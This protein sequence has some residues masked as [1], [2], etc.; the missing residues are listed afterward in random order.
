MGNPKKEKLNLD[1]FRRYGIELELNSFDLRNRSIGYENGRL[2]EGTYYIGNLVQKTIKE[3]VLIHKWGNDHNNDKWIIKPDASCGIEVCTPVCK[4]WHDLKK[5]CKVVDNFASDSKILADD[6]CSLHVHIEVADLS[7]DQV[8][9]IFTWWIKCEPVF[10]D[11]V[12][13]SRKRNRYCQFIG[14]SDFMDNI[15]YGFVS[16]QD[17]LQN[18]GEYKYYSAN[19]YHIYRQKRDSIEFRIMDHSACKDSLAVKNWTRLLLHF[20]ERCVAK[21]MPTNYK[22]NNPWSG[23]QWLDP[24]QVFEFLGF[25]PDQYDLSEGLS[26]TRSWFLSKLL[27]NTLNTNLPGIMSDKAR[28]KAWQETVFLSSKILHNIENTEEFVYSDN[29]RI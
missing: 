21:G 20:V 25:S 19:S 24:C 6:R 14:L 7:L 26:Q 4:G 27:Q 9:T 12:P 11:S 16:T 29:F 5:V 23:Y 28:A 8:A 1:Y 22:E 10:M 3:N 18:L 15:E 2:P 17:L 13:S